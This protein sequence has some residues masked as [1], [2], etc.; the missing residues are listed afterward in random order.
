TAV[1]VSGMAIL[2][3]TLAA[4]IPPLVRQA[5]QF[6]EQAPHYV[7]RVGDHSSWI[8]RLNDLFHVQ[9]RVTELVN[10]SGGPL[11]TEAVKAGTAVFGAFADLLVVAALTVY[12]LVDLPRIRATL[13]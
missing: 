12:F 4:A 7:Q 3:G 11:L 13:Y 10:S 6:M 2:A 9:Q 8:G 5:R 1:L